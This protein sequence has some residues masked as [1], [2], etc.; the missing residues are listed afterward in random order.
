MRRENTEKAPDLVIILAALAALLLTALASLAINAVSN[1][2]SG[3]TAIGVPRVIVPSPNNEWLAARMEFWKN[4]E[5]VRTLSVKNLHDGIYYSLTPEYLEIVQGPDPSV[6]AYIS[7]DSTTNWYTV[8]VYAPDRPTVT[9]SLEKATNIEEPIPH[10]YTV[11]SAGTNLLKKDLAF[12]SDGQYLRYVTRLN[13]EP[14]GINEYEYRT[15]DGIAYLETDDDIKHLTW[16]PPQKPAKL[17]DFMMEK[18]PQIHEET[19]PVWSPDSDA[20]YVH[21]EEGIW[22]VNLLMPRM[23]V[24]ELFLPMQSVRAFCLSADGQHLL[25]TIDGGDGDPSVVLVDLKSADRVPKRIGPGWGAAFSPDS[26]RFVFA[27]TSGLYVG[28]VEKGAAR[29]IETSERRN[30]GRNAAPIWTSDNAAV[31]V[32]SDEG[33]WR[34][35]AD[36]T[37]NGAW[38]LALPLEEVGSFDLSSDGRWLLAES[39]DGVNADRTFN[40]LRKGLQRKDIQRFVDRLGKE[41]R[42]YERN[43][44]LK[45]LHNAEAEPTHVGYGW[46]PMFNAGSG[47]MPMFDAAGDHYFF[48]TYFGLF[49]NSP[50][51]ALPVPHMITIAIWNKL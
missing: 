49:A 6:I 9:Y 40:S 25:A 39:G 13:F 27:H 28:S 18:T 36:S 4:D 17:P 14:L 42:K 47:W 22:R 20:L 11:D 45:D 46:M 44:M 1:A 12:S 30:F 29:R 5:R 15:V 43:L 16:L 31:Y 37:E 23:Q 21:D 35:N 34:V 3:F 26:S 24:W 7:R 51:D 38:E 41:S 8:G 50:E 2:M 10:P 48:G 32:Q 19:V 33:V